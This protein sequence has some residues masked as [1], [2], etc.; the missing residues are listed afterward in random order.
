MTGMGRIFLRL[1]VHLFE[2][3]I[4]EL[5]LLAVGALPEPFIIFVFQFIY[6]EYEEICMSGCIAQPWS[7]SL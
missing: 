5:F 2:W 7:Y 3:K 6:T 1:Q 4:D